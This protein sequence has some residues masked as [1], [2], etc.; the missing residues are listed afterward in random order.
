MNETQQQFDADHDAH[1]D[2]YYAHRALTALA[3][4]DKKIAMLDACAIARGEREGAQE[5]ATRLIGAKKEYSARGAR[6]QHWYRMAWRGGEWTYIGERRLS[7][8]NFLAN[9][10]NDSTSG[11]V[12]E[13]EVCITHDHGGPTDREA[14]LVAR[15]GETY[16]CPV[17]ILRG[18]KIRIDLPDGT[19]IE[20]PNP[21]GG[22]TR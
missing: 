12:Y 18:G 20:R 10:R 5:P 11:D 16:E 13:G 1:V 4:A 21:R 6:R 7:A 9:E 19:S 2:A 17:T 8:G 15:D 3:E 22:R 14:L